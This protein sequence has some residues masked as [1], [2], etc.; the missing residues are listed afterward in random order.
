MQKES[1][2][3]LKLM[4]HNSLKNFMCTLYDGK[5]VDEKDKEELLQYIKGKEE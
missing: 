5:E 4:F 2:R 1:K 3:I